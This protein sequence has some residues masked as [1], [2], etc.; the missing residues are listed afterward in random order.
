MILTLCC[1]L[2]SACATTHIDKRVKH[3]NGKLEY[4]FSP[5]VKCTQIL[6]LHSG[7]ISRA[8][9]F[10]PKALEGINKCSSGKKSEVDIESTLDSLKKIKAAYPWGP[11]YTYEDLDSCFKGPYGGRSYLQVVESIQTLASNFYIACSVDVENEFLKNF[12]EGKNSGEYYINDKA[13]KSLSKKYV[14]RTLGTFSE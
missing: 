12:K 3:V 4:A 5:G 9:K 8:S 6:K 7:F 11:K 13:L 2:L 14:E 10:A 1:V